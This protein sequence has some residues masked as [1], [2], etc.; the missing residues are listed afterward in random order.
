MLVLQLPYPA[1][2]YGLVLDDCT[3]YLV[4]LSPERCQQPCP[5]YWTAVTE[6]NGRSALARLISTKKSCEAGILLNYD[7][8][9]LWMRSLE[10][11]QP[12]GHCIQAVWRINDTS[13]SYVQ[14]AKFYR[15]AMW[16]YVL[17]YSIIKPVAFWPH[18]AYQSCFARSQRTQRYSHGHIMFNTIY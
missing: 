1:C 10:W 7:R 17:S 4:L 12:H 3:S 11:R 15:V 5:F 16:Y 9:V 8:M 13:V 14:T 18:S 2:C 6:R